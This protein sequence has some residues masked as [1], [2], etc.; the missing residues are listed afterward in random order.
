MYM[1]PYLLFNGQCEQAFKLYE[2]CLGGK[3]QALMPFEG[4]PAAEQAPAEWRKKILHACLKVDDQLLMGS[5]CPPEMYEAPKGF[6]VS[7]QP[8]SVAEAE[9]IFHTLAEKGTVKM[10]IQKTFWAARYGMLVDQFGIP[11]SINCEKDS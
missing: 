2:K 6:H 9:R 5:D 8:K 4:T 11:W 3:I 10:P 1:S 7:V